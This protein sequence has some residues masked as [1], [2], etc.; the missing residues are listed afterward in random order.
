MLENGSNRVAKQ[1]KNALEHL[2]S[3]VF[4]KDVAK[5][6]H[7]TP[8]A[9]S[10]YANSTNK[11]GIEVAKPIVDFIGNMKL[12]YSVARQ[13]FNIL[14]FKDDGKVKDDLFAATI[15]QQQQEKERIE[16]Q[17]AAFASA[18][19]PDRQKTSKD[20]ENINR[21]NKEFPEEISSELTMWFSWCVY[22][23]EDPMELIKKVNEKIGG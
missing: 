13:N 7:V 17:A 12:N 14:S 1:L 18:I 11:M 6:A 4:K 16:I 23:H 19:K 2:P 9:L 21:M 15:D 20:W 8:S 5:K 10:Q 22:N 3:G